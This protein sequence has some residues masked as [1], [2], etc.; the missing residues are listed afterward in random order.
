[1]RL[2]SSRSIREDRRPSRQKIS[3]VG[4]SLLAPHYRC[5]WLGRKDSNPRMA[6]S[7]SAALTSLATPQALTLALQERRERLAIQPPH[8]EAARVRGH[9]GMDRP[10]FALGRKFG[11]YAG[12]RA[13]HARIAEPPQPFEMRR[14]FRVAPA[15]DRLEIIHPE[16]G[17]KARYFD[18]LGISCQFERRENLSRRHRDRRYEHDVPRLRQLQRREPLADAF[19]EGVSPEKKEGNVGPERERHRRELLPGEAHAP[20]TI[21]HRQR[22][23]AIGAS[24]AQASAGRNVLLDVDLDSESRLA[25]GLKKARGA[26]RKLLALRDSGKRPRKP[27]PAVLARREA[28]PVASLDQPE[29]GLQ[30]VVAVGTPPDDM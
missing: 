11:K 21:E 7:K 15:H 13:A 29:R 10:R 8:D 30:Q 18:G 14:D 1:M 19:A 2:C 9:P 4:G 12:A 23:G 6:E 5:S 24:P 3:R 27:D 28:Q 26:H 20:E 22:G 25:L 17:R 16:T